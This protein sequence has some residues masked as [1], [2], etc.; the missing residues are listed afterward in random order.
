MMPWLTSGAG[1]MTRA[2]V[3]SDEEFLLR[4]FAASRPE[5]TGLGD[6]VQHQFR[7][8][9]VH[10]RSA[11]PDALHE[12]VLLEDIP[13]GQIRTHWGLE[14]HLVD[15]SILPEYRNRGIGSN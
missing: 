2:V 7:I 6:L 5:L 3:A 11:F 12:I 4:L 15:I 9:A 1:L 14:I 10:Y 13:I 8:Q